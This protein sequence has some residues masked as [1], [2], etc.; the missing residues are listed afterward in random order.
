M[1]QAVVP[2]STVPVV[3]RVFDPDMA[4]RVERAFGIHR[5]LSPAEIDATAFAVAV[6]DAEVVGSISVG[7]KSIVVARATV[8]DGSA[9]AAGGRRAIDSTE[10]RI[11]L[12]R[13]GTEERWAPNIG[14]T[15]PAG[16]SVVVLASQ[17]GLG[18]ALA[19]LRP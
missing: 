3:V 5:S 2:I 6:S 15:L 8:A 14:E 18:P 4:A 13:V 16:A 19:A 10:A 9:A 17:R 1:T 12:A 11:L 7:A